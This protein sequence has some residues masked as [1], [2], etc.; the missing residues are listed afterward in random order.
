MYN[1]KQSV[2]RADKRAAA[3]YVFGYRNIFINIVVRVS[4]V[5]KICIELN[6]RIN[7]ILKKITKQYNNF[8]VIAKH[9][10]VTKVCKYKEILFIDVI[11]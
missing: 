3:N 9:L 1:P 10:E 5:V 7:L 4:Y 2:T 6:V 8:S 11:N